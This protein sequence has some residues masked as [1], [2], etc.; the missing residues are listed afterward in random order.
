M[1]KIFACP[2]TWSSMLIEIPI[3]TLAVWL[4]TEPP[5]TRNMGPSPGAWKVVCRGS[6]PTFSMSNCTAMRVSFLLSGIG[7]LKRWVELRQG[8]LSAAAMS[9]DSQAQMPRRTLPG[10]RRVAPAREPFEE[11]AL[12]LVQRPAGV[13][14]VRARQD[15]E[16]AAPL[17]EDRGQR[18]VV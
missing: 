8:I 17:R 5:T 10:A 13:D 12:Q 15:G 16:P 4:Q 2:T 6:G 3:I 9:M 11:Q 1:E 18:H 7:Q 14:G